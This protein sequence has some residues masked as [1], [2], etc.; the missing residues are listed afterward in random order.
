LEIIFPKG[1]ITSIGKEIEPKQ[2]MIGQ[3]EIIISEQKFIQRIFELLK[4]LSV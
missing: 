2:E 4:N 1:L 3:S